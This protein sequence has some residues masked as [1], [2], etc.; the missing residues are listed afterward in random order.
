MYVQYLD[1]ASIAEG[2]HAEDGADERRDSTSIRVNHVDAS[3]YVQESR[4]GSIPSSSM[5]SFPQP[6]RS[7]ASVDTPCVRGGGGGGRALL[8]RHS[9][10][11][12]VT[13]QQGDSHDDPQLVHKTSASDGHDTPDGV[14]VVLLRGV[15]REC[16]VSDISTSFSQYGTV[17]DVAIYDGN[18]EQATHHE[19]VEIKFWPRPDRVTLLEDLDMQK[20]LFLD[21]GT[22]VT[23]QSMTK[24]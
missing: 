14:C 24:Y 17:A 19:Y 16:S 21:D 12:L 20:R 7:C 11:S 1:D 4:G 13:A 10:L 2:H 5:A 6:P 3:P 9:D 8:P 22:C 23:V 15:P 18:A